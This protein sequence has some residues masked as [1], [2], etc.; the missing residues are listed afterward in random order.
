[1][2]LYIDRRVII[3]FFASMIILMWLGYVSYK[4]NQ[5]FIAT[6]GLVLH[7]NEVL[8]HIEQVN[9]NAIKTEEL[10]SK[11][12]ITGDS[13]YRTDYTREI[14][15][16]RTHYLKLRELTQDNAHQQA[17]IDTF[18]V[19]GRSKFQFHQM[20][21]DTLPKSKTAGEQMLGSA[22]NKNI[23]D[24]IYRVIGDMSRHEKGL[25]TARVNKSL[26]D[27]RGFQ[28][29]FFILML[30]N[31]II[32][33]LVFFMINRSFKARLIAEMKTKQINEELESFTYS[34]SHDLRAPLRSIRGFTEVLKDEYSAKL[35]EEG[36]RL[37]RIVMNNATRMGQLIDDLLDFSRMGRRELSYSDINVRQLVTEVIQE[38]TAHDNRAVQWDVHPL[39]NARGDL[40]ML[41][42]VWVNL[43]SNAI[44]YSRKEGEPKVEIGSEQVKGNLVYYVKDN[45]VGFDMKYSDKL[46]KVFQRLHNHQEFE[47]TGVG[48][49]LIHRIITKHRGKI[50]AESKVNEGTTFYFYTKSLTT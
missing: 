42:Q 48:L 37:L 11:I 28:F 18:L 31:L 4:N 17:L 12:I 29:T 16:A 34:V 15:K 3:G 14:S 30:S 1:M 25:L 38:L 49:A 21:L 27:M 13:S 43:I 20:I 19:Y 40:R 35:D 6:R 39:P 46:F 33:S 45:G 41:K 26:D 2:K 44:K 9:S 24:R 5:D 47:G 50:W 22:L 7:T 8:Q 23:S 32:I 36:N 10:V